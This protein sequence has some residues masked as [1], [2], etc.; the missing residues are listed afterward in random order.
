MLAQ[1]KSI[2]AL[3]NTFCQI[4][5]AYEG[6][7]LKKMYLF[8]DR[9]EDAIRAVETATLSLMT[10]EKAATLSSAMG[11]LTHVGRGIYEVVNRGYY[12]YMK[13]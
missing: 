13:D 9:K 4:I 10:G 11:E 8:V 1:E 7:Y 6:D 3:S 12:I 5:S 2:G